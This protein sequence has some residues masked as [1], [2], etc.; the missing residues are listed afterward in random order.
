MFFE[1]FRRLGAFKRLETTWFGCT[2][3]LR[4]HEIS[5]KTHENAVNFTSFALVLKG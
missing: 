1:G 4:K 5:K 3:G 2:M